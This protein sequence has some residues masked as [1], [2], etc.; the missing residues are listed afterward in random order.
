[1]QYAEVVLPLLSELPSSS[2][3]NDPIRLAG[4]HFFVVLI[5]ADPLA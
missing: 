3:P 4:Q 5:S 1:M 2:S